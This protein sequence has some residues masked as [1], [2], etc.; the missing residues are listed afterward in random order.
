MTMA[1]GRKG[2]PKS[3]LSPGLIGGIVVAVVVIGAIAVLAM[4][5][6]GGATI[7]SDR[8]YVPVTSFSDVH[9]LA[10]SPENADEVYVATHHGLMRGI[11]T[12]AQAQWS[13]V[14]SMQDDLMG[15]SM[16]PTNGSTFWTS[17]HPRGGGNM[18]VRQSTDGGFNWQTTW[19]DR[20]DF[21]AMTASPANPDNLWGYYGGKLYRSTNGGSEWSVV[22]AQPPTT[23][24]LAADP[25]APET[26]Y[27]TTQAGISKSTDAGKTWNALA[28][29][30]AMGIAI[31]PT[32]PKT[33]YAGGQG[34]LWKSTDAGATWTPQQLPRPG[35][36]AYLS[37]SPTRPNTVYAA[38]YETGV[39]RTVD[40]GA[41]WTLV[42]QPDR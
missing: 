7:T 5:N 27:A 36:I 26:I 18:G 2:Q 6:D 40:G 35:T 41:T 37:V 24:A 21:H 28:S 30:A 12:G 32:D 38:S 16:H 4:R 31:D 1:K 23:R 20:V 34:Q 3:K 19:N 15:F 29:I 14:G 10:V 25:E 11:V 42:K 9:G 8:E 13:R 39:Y 17:G 22:N 33:M